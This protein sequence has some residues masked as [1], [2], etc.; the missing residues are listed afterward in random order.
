MNEPSGN[1]I[2]ENL[3][4]E[5]ETAHFSGWDFSYLKGRLVEE[6]P[7][8][9]YREIVIDH[10]SRATTLLDMGTGGGEFLFGLPALPETTHATEGWLPNLEIARQRL[11][12]IGVQVHSFNNDKNLPFADNFFDLIINRHDSFDSQELNRILNPGGIFITQQVGGQDQQ[13]LN[14]FLAPLIKPLYESWFLSSAVQ[15]LKTAG[16]DISFQKEDFP[17]S[18]FLDIGAVV[19]YLKVIEWQIPGFNSKDYHERLLELHHHIQKE[20]AFKSY[21][22]RFIVIAEKP[23]LD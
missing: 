9:D 10:I 23:Q 12:P 8:W 7:A 19:Y 16:F 22:H 13:P 4:T 11:E 18:N 2:F 17:P 15:Q 14:Q 5:A 20:G 3:I 6:G 1:P 21:S